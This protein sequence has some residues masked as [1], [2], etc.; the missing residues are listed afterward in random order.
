MELIKYNNINPDIFQEFHFKH[1]TYLNKCT[2]CSATYILKYHNNYLGIYKYKNSIEIYIKRF[3]TPH[4]LEE[5]I[6]YVINHFKVKNIIA[7]I[8]IKSDHL[9]EIANILYENNFDC[10]QLHTSTPNGNIFKI[11]KLIMIYNCNKNG[12]VHNINK[13]VTDI[14]N[15]LLNTND[16]SFSKSDIS[17]FKGLLE[18]PYE[19]GGDI[20]KINEHLYK[21]NRNSIVDGQFDTIELTPT[22]YNFHTHPI[23]VYNEKN[24]LTFAAWFS[25]VDIRYIVGNIPYGL[26]EHFLIS[27]EGIYRLRPTKQFISEFKKLNDKQ[28]E[29][30]VEQ[31]FNI[32]ANLEDKRVVK[33]KNVLRI[34]SDTIKSFNDFF[35]IINSINSSHFKSLKKDF[36]LFDLEFKFWENFK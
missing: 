33:K 8:S 27:A 17:F 12:N 6:E 16:F 1:K 4:D 32:F 14:Q 13:L 21:V 3:T 35:V 15:K 36:T 28:Q 31:L 24:N 29:H 26:K 23:P 11:P 20:K 2:N 18:L 25:G 5:M 7:C 10:P 34:N 22:T 30:I 19:S 9:K